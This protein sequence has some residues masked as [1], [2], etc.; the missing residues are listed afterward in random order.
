MKEYPIIFTG[1][2]ILAILADRKTQTRRVCKELTG[3]APCNVRFDPPSQM[4]QRYGGGGVWIDLRC[5][6]GVSGD[7][8]WVRETWASV[9]ENHICHPN[10]DYIVYR[11]T[12]PSWSTYE[13]WRWRSPYHMPRWASRITLERVG[14]RP[15]ERL[16][17]ISFEDC[18]AE[19]CDPGYREVVE[20]CPQCTPEQCNGAHYGEKWHF[21]RLWDSLNAKRGHGWDAND[22]VWPVGFRRV[23]EK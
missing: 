1:E 20:P 2:S 21:R 7:R 9:A 15:P 8:L 6:Y 22:W 10:D 14:D 19:G 4:W 12:D 17:E 5:P 11:A 13:D 16:Q 3:Q 18:R 23:V